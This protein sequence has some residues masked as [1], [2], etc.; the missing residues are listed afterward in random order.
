MNLA[1]PLLNSASEAG[2]PGTSLLTMLAD[3]ARLWPDEGPD[4]TV[5]LLMSALSGAAVA[6][7]VA[8]ALTIYFQTGYRS[9][10]DIIRHWVAAAVV[11]GLLGFAAYDMRNAALAYLGINPTKPSAEFEMRWPKAAAARPT[12]G[13]RLAGV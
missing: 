13:L 1:F 2:I 6:M 8:I 5:G 4:G 9:T 10:R 3:A 7:A 12:P 11:L